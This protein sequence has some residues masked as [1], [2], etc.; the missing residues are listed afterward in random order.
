MDS[1]IKSANDVF[2][3]NQIFTSLPGLT[4]QSNNTGY[5]REEIAVLGERNSLQS[6]DRQRFQA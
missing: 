1:R 4:R 6:E 3:L 5:R 2:V